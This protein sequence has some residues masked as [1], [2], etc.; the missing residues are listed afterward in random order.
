MI[1]EMFTKI[2]MSFK[3][4]ELRERLEK[5]DY[6]LNKYAPNMLMK[7]NTA[8]DFEYFETLDD[9]VKGWVKDF[10]ELIKIKMNAEELTTRLYAIPKK[11]TADMKENK[12]NQLLFFKTMYRLLIFCPLWSLWWQKLKKADCQSEF[13]KLILECSLF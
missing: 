7:L 8:P 2:G 6:W 1:E 12:K 4:E 13:K 11:E 9:E 10:C 5:V 3:A